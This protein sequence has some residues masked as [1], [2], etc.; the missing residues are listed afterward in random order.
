MSDLLKRLNIIQ[1]A[2]TLGDE[3]VIALQAGRLPAELQE[4]ADYLVAQKYADA[5]L[6]IAAYRKHNLMLTEYQDPEIAGLRMELANLELALTELV[7]ERSEAL[8][9]IAEFN[10]AYMANLGELMEKILQLRMQQEEARA[11][12]AED[13]ELKKARNQYEEFTQQKADTPQVQSL[14]HEQ[15]NE[16][17]KLFKQAAHKCHPDRLP[18]DKKEDG[19]RMF[20]ELEAANRKNDLAR[21]REIWRLLQDNDWTADAE[22]VTDKDILRQRIAT[23]RERIA[24]VQAKIDAITAD[25]TW[26]LIESLAAEGTRWDAYFAEMK[27]SMEAKLAELERGE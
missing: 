21:V 9:K 25:E 5:A 16:L 18:D 12:H 17:K 14:D 1:D 2:I 7:A 3:D 10:A 22:T 27:T 4:L 19:A 11:A 24:A 6:W 8:R 15:K 26:R 13:D 20:Q 23:T